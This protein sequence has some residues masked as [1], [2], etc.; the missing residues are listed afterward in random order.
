MNPALPQ[1][2]RAVLITALMAMVI[3][4]WF[5]RPLTPWEFDEPLFMSAIERYEPLEHHPPPPGYPLFI[6]VGHVVNSVIR[7]PFS[8][9]VGIS[10]VSSVTGFLFLFLA[11]RNLCGDWR[12]GLVGS[13]LFYLSPAMLIHSTLP[14]SDPPGLMMLSVTLWMASLVRLVASTQTIILFAAF[15]SMTV[16][17]R[18]QLSIAVLPMFFFVVLVWM[19]SGRHRLFALAVFTVVSLIWLLPLVSAVGGVKPFLRW[20]ANQASYFAEHD[21]DVSRTGRSA[22]AIVLRFVAHPWGPKFLSFPLLLTSGVGILSLLRSRNGPSLLM[23]ALSA[24]YLVFCLFMMDPADGARYAL[25]S[26]LGFAF[27]AAVG[28]VEIANLVRFRPLSILLAGCLAV[29]FGWYVAPLITLRATQPSPPVQAAE[30]ARRSL[31]ADTVILYELPLMPHSR[32]LLKDFRTMPIDKGLAQF[33]DKVDVPLV[34]FSDGGTEYRQGTTFQWPFSDA[35]G[36]LTRNHYRVVSLIP[37]PAT[38]RYR[39]VSGVYPMERNVR[40]EEWRWLEPAAALIL[41]DLGLSEVQITLAVPPT[42]PH[43]ETGV[44]FT[45]NGRPWKSAVLK[46]NVPIDFMIPLDEGENRIEIRSEKFFIPAEVKRGLSRD[47]RKLA[48]QL[49]IIEQRGAVRRKIAA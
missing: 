44:D 3:L 12:V 35:Y 48:I 25:P 30:F 21:A 9:L 42:F 33:V 40:G 31:E 7:D 27:V 29:G 49:L 32:R 18:P 26:V 20:E 45:V 43:A 24:P 4:Q 41:P 38:Q 5:L 16:G 19:R 39:P 15:A 17:M 6:G 28:L 8:T 23:A 13:A 47:R 14:I 34:L 37:V 36:K 10:A 2:P 22:A 1:I 11:F 46:R